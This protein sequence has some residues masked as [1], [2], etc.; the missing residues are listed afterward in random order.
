MNKTIK[1]LEKLSNGHGPTGFEGQ[2][3]QIIREEITN[4][5]INIDTDGLG[6]LIC[7]IEKDK[8]FPKIMLSA[9]M[10]ELGLMVR[11][12]TEEGFI[13]FQ[14]LGGWLDQSIVNQRWIIMTKS[15]NIKGVTGIKTV[16]VMNETERKQIFPKDNLF[17]DVGAKDKKDAE[18]RLGILPGDPISPDSSFEFLN[19]ENML[20]GKAWDDRVGVALLIETLN[21]LDTKNL[22]NNVFGSCTVQEEVGL[23]GAITSSYTIAPDINI[24]LEVGVAGDYP[25][26]NPNLAQEKLSSGPSIFLHDSSMIPNLKLRDFCIDT[27]KKLSIPI[28]FSVISGYGEDGAAAQKSFGGIPAINIG[29]PTRYLHSHNGIIDLND[30]IK[31]KTLVKSLVENLDT[32]TVKSIKSFD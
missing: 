11:Y 5:E 6:S 23:R 29:I 16:H 18:E 13:K 8:Q 3:R 10:D 14:T 4:P 26:M 20:L 32:T 21:S 7:K 1:L 27:A 24:N 22:P 15:G 17:I 30:F 31:A 2:I 28:Q 25:G 19:S 12:I 9:H